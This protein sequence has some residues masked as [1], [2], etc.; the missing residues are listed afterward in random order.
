MKKLLLTSLLSVSFILTYAQFNF[1]TNTLIGQQLVTV[2]T[3]STFTVN[4]DNL[5]TAN[6]GTTV[7][8]CASWTGTS[9][10]YTL[11]FQKCQTQKGLQVMSYADATTTSDTRSN[12]FKCY[13]YGTNENPCRVYNMDSLISVMRKS[14][15]NGTATN[16]PSYPAACLFGI[17]SANAYSHVYLA[18]S[19]RK[20][21]VKRNS[22]SG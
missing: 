12:D 18:I 10:P 5:T 1:A 9:V 11:N 2:G 21:F 19:G 15:A 8:E 4:F 22:K 7:R 20:S 6:G 3:Q 17:S 13:R 14:A 16:G